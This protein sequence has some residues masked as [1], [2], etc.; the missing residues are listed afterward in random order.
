MP[1]D[2]NIQS[3]KNIKEATENDT[4]RHRYTTMQESR[5]IRITIEEGRVHETEVCADVF[6]TKTK[7]SKLMK[8]IELCHKYTK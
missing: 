6:Q 4:Q 7:R 3:N 2:S 8:Q 5:K 1:D